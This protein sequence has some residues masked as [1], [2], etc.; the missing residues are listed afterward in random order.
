MPPA[1]GD[2]IVVMDMVYKPLETP[3]LRESRALGHRTVDGLDMLIG[4]A[5]PAFEAFFGVAPPDI[6]VREL[7]LA[8]MERPTELRP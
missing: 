4:Q 5:V 1:K 6:P 8:V 2:P 3:F 7:L